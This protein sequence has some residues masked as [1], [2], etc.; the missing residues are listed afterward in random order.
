[1]RL[2]IDT[3]L[4]GL[5]FYGDRFGFA[6]TSHE[7]GAHLVGVSQAIDVQGANVDLRLGDWREK[8]ITASI[9]P[10]SSAITEFDGLLGARAFARHRFAF[11]FDRMI[12]AWD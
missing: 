10:N 11:D 1:M 7:L 6:Q 2:Q 4:N 5:V 8:H 9:I 12:V 3:G